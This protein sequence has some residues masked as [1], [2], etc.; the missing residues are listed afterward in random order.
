MFDSNYINTVYENYK[1]NNRFG[2]PNNYLYQLL[3]DIK[4]KNLVEDFKQDLLTEAKVLEDSF[5]NA[6]VRKENLNAKIINNLVY[7]F[8][9]LQNKF[10]HLSYVLFN[11]NLHKEYDVKIDNKFTKSLLKEAEYYKKHFTSKEK[12]ILSSY[13]YNNIFELDI[14][15]I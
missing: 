9:I 1:K 15:L 5:I 10:K 4:N 3:D 14:E 2:G 6:F 12:E 11:S 13:D 8:T 7:D